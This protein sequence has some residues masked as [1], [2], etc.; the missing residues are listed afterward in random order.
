[1]LAIDCYYLQYKWILKINFLLNFLINKNVFRTIF[2]DAKP[3][4]FFKS[5]WQNESE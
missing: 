1:M 5:K 4:Y 3:D 2:F